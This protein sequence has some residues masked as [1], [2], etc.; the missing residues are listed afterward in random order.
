MISKKIRN[1]QPIKLLSILLRFKNG[2]PPHYSMLGTSF[3]PFYKTHFFFRIVVKKNDVDF[4]MLAAK[5]YH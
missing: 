2:Y 4:Q 1:A 3:Y 5:E